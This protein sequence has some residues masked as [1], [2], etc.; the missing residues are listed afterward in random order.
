MS[1][2]KKL[3]KASVSPAEASKVKQSTGSHGR[4]RGMVSKAVA[5]RLC[6]E[7]DLAAGKEILASRYK[8]F[9]T[10][11]LTPSAKEKGGVLARDPQWRAEFESWVDG[12]WS[13]HG[14]G[15]AWSVVRG[16]DALWPDDCSINARRATMLSL[17]NMRVIE[18]TRTPFSM[19]IRKRMGAVT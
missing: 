3:V 5:C 2:G 4:S 8:H 11:K 10:P 19:K 9:P 16:T 14:H 18:H 6:P 15:P 17:A 7:V 12:Y 13:A 1:T